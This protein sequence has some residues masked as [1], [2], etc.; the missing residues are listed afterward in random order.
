MKQSLNMRYYYYNK[1]SISKMGLD[2]VFMQHTSAFAG[3]GKI[4]CFLQFSF[5]NKPA[6][7]AANLGIWYCASGC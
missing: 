2:L 4:L 3:H 7:V 1:N 5:K 6:Q